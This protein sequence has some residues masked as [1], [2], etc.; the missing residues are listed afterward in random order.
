MA[1]NQASNER[2]KV[3]ANAAAQRELQLATKAEELHKLLE[4][5]IAEGIERTVFLENKVDSQ[6]KYIKANASGIKKKQRT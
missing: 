4:N 6:K 2:A 1:K 5:H 3:D